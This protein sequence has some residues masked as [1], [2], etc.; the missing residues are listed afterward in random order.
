MRLRLDAE[1]FLDESQVAVI[2][3]QQ[4]VEMPVVLEGHD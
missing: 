3:P 4:P 2:L 1:T